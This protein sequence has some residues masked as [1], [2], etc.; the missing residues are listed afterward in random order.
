MCALHI[1][2]CDHCMGYSASVLVTIVPTTPH[3]PSLVI[4][5]WS[6]GM[7]PANTPATWNLAKARAVQLMSFDV[8][9]AF[10]WAVVV[11]CKVLVVY[12]Q[13]RGVC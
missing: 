4:G 13:P 12:S 5:F 6:N 9:K 3:W 10:D 8:L 2:A 1:F 7:E 11:A